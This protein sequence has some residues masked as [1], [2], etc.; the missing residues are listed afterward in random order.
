VIQE[1]V[2][3]F[4]IKRSAH[5][6]PRLRWRVGHGRPKEK[7][8]M[9]VGATVVLR[10]TTLPHLGTPRYLRKIKSRSFDRDARGRWYCNLVVE[11]EGPAAIKR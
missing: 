9:D 6:K 1:V 7:S 10:W 2:D 4:I 5:G 8:W 11:V 3:E